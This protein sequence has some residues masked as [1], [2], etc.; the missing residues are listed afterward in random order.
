MHQSVC[1][2][3]I[4]L[5]FRGHHGVTEAERTGGID[6][7]ANIH[8]FHNDVKM[9]E[10]DNIIHGVNYV[11]L[12]ELM[13]ETNSHQE[14]KTLEAMASHFAGCVFDRYPIIAK[15]DVSLTKPTPMTS[16]PVG[17]LGVTCE[18]YNPNH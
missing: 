1:V 14:F 4:D 16:L 11:T 7:V 10:S 9:S 6:L 2:K 5:K 13:L 3:V 12:A 15:L 8:A 18:F 17:G